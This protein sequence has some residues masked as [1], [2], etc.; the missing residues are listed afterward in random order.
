LF[1]RGIGLTVLQIA[2]M[3]EEKAEKNTLSEISSVTL[4]PNDDEK[5]DTD[6]DSDDEET[7]EPKNID[8]FGPG[9]LSSLA[10]VDFVNDE[11]LPDI[12][13]VLTYNN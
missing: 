2:A 11:E 6:G 7:V 12:T 13:E 10:E 4:I 5:A 3:L 1:S 9:I 8:H